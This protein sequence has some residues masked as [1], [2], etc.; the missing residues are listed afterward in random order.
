MNK[1]NKEY[2]F[3]FAYHMA[4]NDATL[5]KAYFGKKKDIEEIK[6]VRST[7]KNYID[8]IFNGK[9]K[10][11]ESVSKEIEN[12]VVGKNFSFGNIQKLIN[13][14]A[15]YM[16]ISCYA[17]ESVRN[18]FSDCHCPMDG[19][20]RDNVFRI[21]K[22]LF[23]EKLGFKDVSWSKNLTWKHY[24]DFQSAIKRIIEELSLDCIPIEFDFLIW[25]LKIE[26]GTTRDILINDLKALI[27]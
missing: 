20:M 10:D 4:L 18:K 22:I 24:M 6:E 3:D 21:Y 11:F 5:Q 19:I 8:S 12:E 1:E 14:T 25:N 9:K 13:M 7:V 17:D 2:I 26:K 15:K 16:Y 23:G 27:K